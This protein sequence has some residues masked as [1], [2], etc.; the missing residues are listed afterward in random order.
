VE[1]PGR[2]CAVCFAATGF[3]AEPCC[4]RCGTPF[5][6]AM[7]GGPERICDACRADP[8][9]WAHARGALRYDAQGRRAV[10]PLK[11]G[12]RPELAR[13]LAPHML[14][15]GHALLRAAD[16]LVPVPLHRRRLIARRYNQAALLAS[17]LGRLAGRP[18][19]AD[20]LERVRPTAPLAELSA[21]ARAEELRDAIRVRPRRAAAL[22]A[23]RV[24][25]VDD[26]LTSGATARACARALLAAGAEAVD[27]LVA[28]RVPDPRRHRG[29]AARSRLPS[30]A[31]DPTL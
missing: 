8:P 5:A 22:A 12:D 21:A 26:V 23:R 10:L 7:E 3:I 31:A 28:A 15:A 11:Y 14:R 30:A 2:F 4:D 9:P 16:L 18:V 25:L 20:A 17:A 1:A 19:I 24:L 6:T 13:A 27:V 29:A